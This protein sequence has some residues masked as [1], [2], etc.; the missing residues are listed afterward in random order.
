VPLAHDVVLQSASAM[1]ALK[2]MSMEAKLRPLIVA[3]APPLVG[4]LPLPTRLNDTTG[5]DTR[6]L[7]TD[8]FKRTL[9]AA[10]YRQM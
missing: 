9:Y 2:V 1:A 7:D 6:W 8:T 5:A 3:L 10:K 4:A